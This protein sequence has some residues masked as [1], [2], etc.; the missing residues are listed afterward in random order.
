MSPSQKHHSRQRSLVRL[1]LAAFGLAILFAV[2]SAPGLTQQQDPL[3]VVKV[4]T[5]LVV[6]DAQVI[7]KKTKRV[8]G[9]LSKDN[10]ELS[11][12]GSR[13]QIRKLK[14]AHIMMDFA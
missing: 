10:F 13:Q 7:D 9:D 8:I 5:D 12:N 6:F 1:I 14:V 3:D 4:N 11:D 2:S